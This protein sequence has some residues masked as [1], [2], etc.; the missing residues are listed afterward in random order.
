[1]YVGDRLGP[2]AQ[3]QFDQRPRRTEYR[4]PE[5]SLWQHADIRPLELDI[6]GKRNGDAARC[7]QIALETRENPIERAQTAGEQAMGV[8]ILRRAGP[9]S[10]GCRQVIAFDDLDPIKIFG[11]GASGRK[12]TNS[13]SNNERPPTELKRTAAIPQSRE[14]RWV[15]AHRAKIFFRSGL[16]FSSPLEALRELIR[17]HAM[18]C[19]FW[20]CGLRD[21]FRFAEFGYA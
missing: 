20:C 17:L 10:S 2:S 6:A 8:P 21:D 3:H 18:H 11:Q 12:P 9:R 5:I 19:E 15:L 14:K 13:R 7:G 4:D 1:V 16:P